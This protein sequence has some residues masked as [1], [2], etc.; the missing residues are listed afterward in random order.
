MDDLIEGYRRFRLHGWVERRKMFEELAE[1]GQKPRTMILGCID[2][3]VDPAI[4]FDTRPGEI[5]TVRNVA[6]LVP[7]YEPGGA[8]GTS[9]ALEFGVR[10]LGVEHLVVLGHGSCGGVKA[11]LEGAP[12]QA[13]DFVAPWMRIAQAARVRALASAHDAASCQRCGEYEVIKLSLANLMG[14]PWIAERVQAG[15]LQLHGAWF[16]VHSGELL[17][18]DGAGHFI[19]V[20]EGASPLG[21]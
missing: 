1:T 3:R 10:V 21:G 11:L 2:S 14:F 13:H 4:I 6:N 9:A 20:D 15:T 5:L 19:P 16:A 18:L 8:R 12:D 17:I 7:P